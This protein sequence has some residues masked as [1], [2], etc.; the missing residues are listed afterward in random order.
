MAAEGRVGTQVSD[1]S[2]PGGL[3]ER[4]IPGPY[5][6]RLHRI[7]AVIAALAA[8]TTDLLSV[9]VILARL[10]VGPAAPGFL[11]LA[12]LVGLP[13]AAGLLVAAVAIPSRRGASPV[14]RA[15]SDVPIGPADRT[16]HTLLAL[17]ILWY[18]LLL[19]VVPFPAQ[20]LTPTAPALAPDQDFIVSS[21][22]PVVVASPLVLPRRARF[23]YAVALA[24]LSVL[25]LVRTGAEPGLDMAQAPIFLLAFNLLFLAAATWVLDQARRLD[26]AH[27]VREGQEA[28]T[29]IASARN[30]ARRRMN[31]FV[32][33]HVLSAL[34]PLAN[35][36][37]DDT[38]LRSAAR[39]AVL[40]LEG[41]VAGDDVATSATL[42]DTIVRRSRMVCPEVSIAVSVGVDHA[43]PPE[44]GCAVLDAVGEAL[45]NSLRHAGGQDPCLRVGR[46]VALVSDGAG[47]SVAVAD[48]GRG[49]DP[50]EVP[51]G[52]HGIPHSII[53]RME[54]A[55]GSARVEPGAG[56]G[57]R[58]ELVWRRPPEGIGGTLGGASPRAAEG[59]TAAPGTVAPA[60]VAHGSASGG[61]GAGGG[62]PVARTGRVPRGGAR[63]REGAAVGRREVELPW[64]VSVSSSMQT[65]PARVVGACAL[66]A[67]VFL[68]VANT[69]VYTQLA[70]AVLALVAQGAVGVLLLWDWPGARLPRW[71]A[72]SAPLVIGASN[73]AVLL[74]IPTPG[75]P[76]Y[77]AWTLGSATMLCWGLI[78]RERR[79]AAWAGWVLLVATTVVWVLITG[80]PLILAASMT[81]GHM[82]TIALWDLV[83][84]WSGRVAE[85]IAADE[86]RQIELVAEQRAQEEV[87][88]LQDGALAS[89]AD[90]ALPLLGAVASGADLVPALRTRA[91]LLEA[92]LRDEIRAPCFTGTRVVPAARAARG[93]GVDVVLLDDGPESPVGEVL[94]G[95]LVAEAARLL[96]GTETGRVVVRRLP[97]GRRVAATLVAEGTH[98]TLS[99][100]GAISQ[101]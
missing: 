64:G 31:D 85:T 59:G 60:S 38:R 6:V 11:R 45:T 48:D 14:D 47:V 97:P 84:T 58:V 56:R 80:R 91:R 19:A 9:P 94:E 3:L 27:Q 17:L 100:D 77:A 93:R 2:R 15:T 25:F 51:T 72:V 40:S 20:G 1:R 44:L 76:G 10:A 61:T 89:V 29:R 12:P 18:P 7:I 79:Y 35:G 26:V 39:L 21:S 69:Q 8:L 71:V 83:A 81:V 99:A 88:R 16:W 70:P 55:G 28:T 87:R 30:R 82:A 37:E 33:D 52:R 41:S 5:S 73:M 4:S 92:E 42:F 75:W 78:M 86:R 68:L 23:G 46:S 13:I 95:A 49:F 36:L 50:R 34:V 32:H 67:H 24:P 22:T 66:L 98:L 43:L 62:E 63:R 57:T 54:E 53:R 90:R 74:V 96:E 101:D 65:L